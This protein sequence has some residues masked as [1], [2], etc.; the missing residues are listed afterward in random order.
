MKRLLLLLLL[1][2]GCGS[3]D[4]GV[5]ICEHPNGESYTFDTATCKGCG[6]PIGYFHTDGYFCQKI[7]PTGT[8]IDEAIAVYRAADA[9]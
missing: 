8:P 6:D 5:Y 4:Q 9:I 3:Q 1:L 7:A 2:P